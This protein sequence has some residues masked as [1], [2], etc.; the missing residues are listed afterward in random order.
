MVI[1]KRQ[2][3]DTWDVAELETAIRS[4]NMPQAPVKLDQCT[5]IIDVPLFIESHLSTVKHNNGNP[6]FKP[7]FD[8]LVKFKNLMI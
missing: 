1:K 3:P 6:H 5:T 2:K 4:A 8:R 7:Y